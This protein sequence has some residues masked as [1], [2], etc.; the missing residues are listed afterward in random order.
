MK[1]EKKNKTEEKIVCL[2][3]FSVNVD[4]SVVVLML[5]SQLR[6]HK[7]ERIKL[8]KFNKILFFFLSKLEK[9]NCQLLI[10]LI[11]MI[12]TVCQ[13][14]IRFKQFELNKTYE[15]KTSF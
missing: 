7:F 15:H 4:V 14:N 2:Q 5:S 11:K 12:I 3:I 10:V 1:W 9:K 8:L 6:A 13:T